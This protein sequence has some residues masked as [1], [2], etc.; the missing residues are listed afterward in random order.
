LNNRFIHLFILL[1]IPGLSIGQELRLQQFTMKDG[2]S[3]PGTYWLESII[4]DRE[5]FLWFTTFNGL[6]R[7]DGKNFKIFQYSQNYPKSLGNNFTTAICEA[8]DGS[9]WVGTNS[10][11][12]IFD[13]ETETFDLLQ[14]DPANPKSLCGNDINFINKDRDGNMWVGTAVDGVCRWSKATGDFEDFGG[15][16]RDGLVFFQQ[17]NGAIWVGNTDGLHQK[18]AGKDAFLLIELPAAFK[19]KKIRYASDIVEL[20]DGSLMVSSYGAGLWTFN[21]KTRKFKDITASFQSKFIKSPTCLLTDSEGQIW[22]G[23]LDEIQ[24]YDPA[25]GAFKVYAHDDDDPASVPKYKV[26]YGYQDAAGSLWFITPGGGVI[27]AHSPRHPFE[28]VGSIHNER[29]IRLDENRL[30]I[31]SWER[32]AVFDVRDQKLA[33][34]EIPES[35]LNVPRVAVAL[36]GKNELWLQQFDTRHVEVF[37]FD[38]RTTRQIPGRTALLKTGPEGK[39]WSGF[40]YFD[41]A[42]NQWVVLDLNIPGQPDAAKFDRE[43]VDLFFGENNALWLATNF[44]VFQYNLETRQ[45]RKYHL[46]PGD[47]VATDVVYKIFPGQAGRFY[48]STSNGMS[49]YDP[50]TDGF[51]SFNESNGLLHNQVTSVVEDTHGNPWLTTPKGLHKLDL[52][53]GAFTNYGINDGLPDTDFTYQQAYRDDAGQLYFSVDGNLLRFHPDSLKPRAYVASVHLLD[54]YLN[55][56]KVQPGGQDAL[57]KKQLRFSQQ[58]QLRHNQADFGFSFVMPVFYKAGEVQY[59]YQLAP[60]DADWQSAGTRNEVHYTN[61]DPGKY[62]FRVKAKTADG[63]WSPNEASVNIHISP[64]FYRTWWAYLFYTLAAGSLLFWIRRFELRR[65][66]M[67]AEAIRMQELD[68]LKTRLYTNITHEF[69]TPLTVIMGMTEQL[70]AGSWQ[71]AVSTEDKG[72]LGSAFSL[73]RRNSKNLLRLINQMLDLS[74]FDSG[75]LKMDLVQGDI[76]NYLQYLTES[77]HSMAH[78]KNVRLTFYAEVPELVMD[79]DEVKIQHIIYNLLSNAIKFTETGGKV[80]LHANQTESNGQPFLKL[81]IQDTGI[82]IPE[83]QL[84][85]IFDRFYQADSSHT[86]KWEGSG[87]G[88]A[89]TKEL[90]GLMGGT[91]SVESTVGKGTIFTLLLPVRLGAV[92]PLSPGAFQS[93]RTLAPEPAP[94]W[95]ATS[96][97]PHTGDATLGLVGEKPLLLIIEDNA[98]VVTY[99]AGLLEKEYEIHTAPNG[100]A[101]I[102]KAYELVPDIIISDVMMPEKDGY[103]VCETLKTDERTSHI[104]IILLTAKAEASDRITGLRKGADAYLMKPFNKEELFVRLE[105][106]LE[107]RRALQQRYAAASAGIAPDPEASAPTLEDIFLQKLQN[108]V[109]ENLDDPSLGAEE[110]SRAV[111]LSPS[112]LYRKLN[113][114]TGEPPNAF[115]RKIRLHQAMTLLKTT[116]RNI[117]EIAYDVGFN[118]PN[119]FSRVFSKEFGDTPREY[120]K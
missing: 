82:G 77:F 106:L 9:I 109:L 70:A 30:L 112:Q 117:S 26:A 15:Y 91:I 51:L 38:T 52:S 114:L 46:N 64:P 113:A 73:I 71:S 33:A 76:I 86:R 60:Y 39:I 72:K 48:L 59:F 13:P 53:S 78:E 17:K 110:L 50:A 95:S 101:G 5:G 8:E 115:I 108:A 63:F 80:V 99:I 42:K 18:I 44:G 62:T 31:N 55:H 96:T 65:Q 84:A 120:R 24:R 103:E 116:D 19:Q 83:G 41:E 10:G 75:A 57:L 105:K 36:S 21:P 56:E 111:L 2:L 87:I 16:F 81:K 54:F 20:P 66:M 118:D 94:E 107:L 35:L 28:I 49:L 100:R 89:L 11:V 3:H 67:K 69:R 85:H 68:T 14:H 43:V 61:I 25:S 7:F 4:Q 98:D 12:Y 58:V 29:V 37:N 45:G 97:P 6:N 119:Y 92:T 27:V 47:P 104:P 102:E 32:L 90:V 88:L 22:M 93:A 1:A 79:F 34:P 40:K 74:K 23:A